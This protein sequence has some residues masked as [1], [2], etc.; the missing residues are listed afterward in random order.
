MIFEALP[1]SERA[2]LEASRRYGEHVRLNTDEQ[3]IA[4][5]S[6]IRW[7]IIVCEEV[8]TPSSENRFLGAAAVLRSQAFEIGG[9]ESLQ[10]SLESAVVLPW[11][12]R[13]G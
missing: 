9:L 12:H 11:L 4:E 10:D 8:C 7:S 13:R 5:S 1:N 3:A 2:R 6:S